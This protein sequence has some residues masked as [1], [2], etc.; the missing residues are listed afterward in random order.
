MKLG[1]HNGVANLFDKF[2]IKGE[3]GDLIRNA[4]YLEMLPSPAH[5][6]KAITEWLTDEIFDRYSSIQSAAST[7]AKPR[8]SSHRARVWISAIA[9]ATI[10]GLSLVL[11]SRFQQP[12]QQEPQ[13]ARQK[14]NL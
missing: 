8:Q 1:I 6:F 5:N 14:S 9:V 2:Q 13:P 4:T 10:L 3:A 12:F 7:Q 11:T